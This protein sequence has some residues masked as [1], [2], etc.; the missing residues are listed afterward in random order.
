MNKVHKITNAKATVVD[1]KNHVIDF[2]ISDESRDRQGDIVKQNGWIL[3]NYMKNPVVLFGHDSWSFPIG[4]ALKIVTDA[5]S[6]KTV[7]SI[8]F[9]A[10][11]YDKALTAFKLCKGGY[12]NT[13]S[14]G[15]I[16]KEREGNELQVNELLE[17]SIVPVPA[18]P[19]AFALAFDSGEI[20]K[21]D[22]QWLMK[23]FETSID[24]L[25]KTMQ[26]KKEGNIMTDEEKQLLNKTAESV[27]EMSTTLKTVLEN[28]TKMLEKMSDTPKKKDVTDDTSGDTPAAGDAPAAGD[29]ATPVPNPDDAPVVPAT[30]DD[31][32][33]VTPA[34]PA[35]DGG[36]DE[37]TDETEVDPE[38][39][40]EEEGKAFQAALRKRLEGAEAK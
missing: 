26:N 10:D 35:T 12:L 32:G 28:Q 23:N 31:N 5:V 34:K 21:D 19:N 20:S 30:T 33:S 17:I 39:M 18:N 27:T 38:N 16:N 40:T 2:I 9:A 14:V 7:A 15:F 36:A 4:K 6:N 1:E 29:P 11:E 22:A 24:S 13:T 25:K 3:D 8:Q 37:I